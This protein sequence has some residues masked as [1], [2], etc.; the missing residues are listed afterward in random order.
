MTKH[1][2]PNPTAAIHVLTYMYLLVTTL[3]RELESFGHSLELDEVVFVYYMIDKD[4]SKHV[5][6]LEN[7]NKEDIDSWVLL[8]ELEV[9]LKVAGTAGNHVGESDD[10]YDVE[11]HDLDEEM[12]VE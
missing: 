4:E 1:K 9:P 6:E 2:N 10:E 8:E 5:L 7:Y 11:N 3:E 12:D